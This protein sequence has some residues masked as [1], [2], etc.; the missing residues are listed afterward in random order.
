MDRNWNI[1]KEIEHFKE[2]WSYRRSGHAFHTKEAW[3]VRADEWVSELKTDEVFRENSKKRVA[4]TVEYLLAR[5]ALGENQDVIDIGCGPGQFVTGFAKHCRLAVGTDLS[6]QML[7]YGARYA[8]EAGLKNTSYVEA[9]FQKADID[10]LG[11]RWR[12][13]L[14]FSSITPAIGGETGLEKL[15]QMSRGYCFNSCFVHFED[16]L[17]AE[18][19]KN[20]LNMEKVDSWNGH[21][22]WYYALFNLLWLEGY[23]PETTYYKEEK[24]RVF[25]AD[26][27][28]AARYA[29]KLAKTYGRDKKG[30]EA[31]ILRYLKEKADREGNVVEKGACWYGWLLWDVRTRTE[32]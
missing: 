11:W 25:P 32:R 19:A 3:D 28:T 30:L 18:L 22:H 12:F 24:L 31:P 16:E 2:I 29:E 27:N 17:E 8:E 5:G 15:M 7:A 4:A 26:E 1:S 10:A 14:V 6:P 9:D 20:V 23:Y 13:D 21:W